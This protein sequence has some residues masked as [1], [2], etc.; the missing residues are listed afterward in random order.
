MTNATRTMGTEGHPPHVR[1]IIGGARRSRT[2]G[3]T[4]LEVMIAVPL[5]A[6]LLMGTIGLFTIS[7]QTLAKTSADVFASAD[8]SNSIEHVI[9]LTREA[10][11][12]ALP[13][14]NT[15]VLPANY[16]LNN[17]STVD[18]GET[19]DT[20]IELNLPP[21]LVPSNVGYQAG[22][23]AQISVMNS[24][25]TILT[26]TPIPYFHDGASTAG[27]LIYRGDPNGAPDA[28]P[29]G[30]NVVNAGTYLWECSVTGGMAATPTALCKSIA[31]AANAVQFV[32]P[33]S[34][35]D[36]TGTPEPYQV[37]VKIVS[38]YYSPINSQQTNEET[39]GSQV[40]QLTGKC[41][42]MRDHLTQAST[43][44]NANTQAS[45]NA[46]TFTH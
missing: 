18:A 12:F 36:G 46:F 25:G 44:S 22:D 13:T 30:S 3:F 43:P 34:N 26:V 27:V 35:P 9:D 19:I 23:P 16:S 38:A 42:Y 33:T 28:N 11:S 10:Q 41:V 40:S 17:L 4:L 24:S 21:T 31:A 45:N 6:M 5:A 8:A 29:S 37:E 20:A 2:R 1:T 32:R 14:E 15:F 7:T 39:N